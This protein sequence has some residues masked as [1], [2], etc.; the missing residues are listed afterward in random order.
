MVSSIF[1]AIC[2]FIFL[3][4]EKYLL[5]QITLFLLIDF[6]DILYTFHYKVLFF[7]MSKFFGSSSESSDSEDSDKVV[8][9]RQT[10]KPKPKTFEFLSDSDDEGP[11]RVVM[12]AKDKAYKELKD[13]IRHCRNCEKI[14]DMTKLLTC[15]LITNQISLTL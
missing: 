6:D 1:L 9:Q 13:Q 2:L 4:D 3:L 11:R 8:D 15:K 12:A 5:A 14:N 7:Q 10:G